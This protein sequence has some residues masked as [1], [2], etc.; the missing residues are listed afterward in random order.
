MAR[1]AS[2]LI[3]SGDEAVVLTPATHTA[4]A[5][6]TI[7]KRRLFAINADQDITIR[8]GLSTGNMTTVDNA[9]YRIPANS[10]DVFDLGDAFDSFQ[11]YN[12]SG[13]TANV[14]YQTLTVN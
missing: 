10:Q 13:V 7:G 12:L 3:P 5:T 14:Y 8:F 11:V 9:D 6:Q 2:I 4:S 1:Q